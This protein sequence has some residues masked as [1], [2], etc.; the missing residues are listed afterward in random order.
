GGK[1]SMDRASGSGVFARDPD[2]LIDL[3][4]LE[5]TETLIKQE[6]DKAVCSIY[7]KAIEN[8]NYDYFDEH[9]GQDDLLSVK[10]MSDHVSRAIPNKLNELEQEIERVK[11]KI[12]IRSAWRVEG[13][14]REYPS[15]EPVNMWF[16]YPI[17]EIDNV[18]S[19]KDLEPEGEQPPW[20]KNFTKKKTNEER[21]N[22]RKKAIETAFEACGI[23]DDVT[24]DSLAEYMGVSDKTVRNRIKEHGG[25]WIDEGNV[26]KK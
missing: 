26:G 3:T 13:T 22:E 5:V 7:G 12:K 14:L 25:F 23:D 20:K 24:I 8:N 9:V 18:G 15:F 21:K 2:A 1:K 10:Q 16:Q 6:I 4:E 11:K 17:H 19:L